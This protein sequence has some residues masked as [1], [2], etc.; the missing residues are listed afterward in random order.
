MAGRLSEVDTILLHSQ[1][2]A[3]A[4]QMCVRL[5]SWNTALELARRNGQ[6]ANDSLNSVLLQRREY[7]R[8]L[9]RDEYLPKFLELLDAGNSQ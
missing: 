5:H 9:D 1:A 3:D 4:I 6:S 2:S 8:A 7:L